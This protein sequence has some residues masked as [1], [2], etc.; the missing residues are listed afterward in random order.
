MIKYDKYVKNENTLPMESG[1]VSIISLFLEFFLLAQEDTHPALQTLPK[2]SNLTILGN[3][4]FVTLQ[5]LS[6]NLYLNLA[7]TTIIRCS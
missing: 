1:Y 6:S 5:N 7:Q 2:L 3:D 4:L